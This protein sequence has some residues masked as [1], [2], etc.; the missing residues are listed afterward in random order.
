MGTEICRGKSYEKTSKYSRISIKE[1]SNTSSSRY[2]DEEI[3]AA[4][5]GDT[6]EISVTSVNSVYLSP[7]F[8][9]SS[10]HCVATS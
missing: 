6:A 3:N 2:L 4:V 8:T 1:C 10:P 5:S 7:F 9:D